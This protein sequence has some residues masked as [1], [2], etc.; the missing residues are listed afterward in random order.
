MRF[1]RQY[2]GMARQPDRTT[3]RVA[4]KYL[5]KI[6]A[7]WTMT[8]TANNHGSIGADAALEFLELLRPGGSWQIIAITADNEAPIVTVT[9]VDKQVVEQFI[10]K[11]IGKRNLYFTPNPVRPSAP[12]DKKPTK[13]EIA[14]IEYVYADLDP[15]DDETPEQAKARYF[16]AL[17]SSEQQP[18]FVVD[19]GNGLQA[20]FRVTPI[21]LPEPLDVIG[22]NNSRGLAYDSVTLA[23]IAN[24]EARIRALVLSLGGTAGTQN[25]DRALRLPG[26]V[27]VPN[28]A[29]R[30][31]GRVHCSTALLSAS[32]AER[33]I[34]DFPLP[35]D[36]QP[37][38]SAAAHASANNGEDELFRT[39]R[40]GGEKRHGAS[41][42]EAVWYVCCEMLRRGYLKKTIVKTLL[43]RA[44]AISAHVY[45][46][47][48]P[49]AYAEKQAA[50]AAAK[51]D[52]VLD[53]DTRP[54]KT[55]GNVR[56]ALVKLGIEL[57]YDS[58]AGRVLIEG[59][60]DFD[61]LDDAA[62]VRIWLTIDRRFSL[63][64]T[65]T[66]V[67]DVLLDVAQINAFHPVRDYLAGLKWD[68]EP[69]LDRWLTIY[70]GAVDNK[71]TN[72]VGALP[73]IAA[74]RRVRQPGVKFDEMLVLEHPVQGVS[75]RSS[76]LAIM[77]V[78]DEWFSDDLPLNVETKEFIER[79]RGR[80]IIEAGELAGLRKADVNHLKGLL[81]RR[82]DRARLAYGRLETECP[83]QC[84]IIATTNAQLYL[85]D[86][87]GNRRMWAVRVD[88]FDIEKL[89]ADRDQIWAEAAHRE[90]TG[91]SIRLDSSLWPVAE[92]EQAQRLID[93]P[94][95]ETLL[96]ELG[97]GF[98]QS[99]IS[100]EAVWVILDVKPGARTQELNCRMGDAMRRAGW[101][102]ANAANQVRIDGKK[103][104]G[105]TRGE[106]PW[107]TVRVRRSLN[108]GLVI[109]RSEL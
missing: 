72:A 47:A 96:S 63:R 28:K 93:D 4:D 83:R 51:L 17:E 3:R 70:G 105:Y 68:G 65:K 41:R 26:T 40:D 94:Y 90:A 31:R 36:A 102:R 61:K 18:T 8:D 34:E 86:L 99:K 15:R 80:W 71:Y 21:S 60:D 67:F 106:Q 77:A 64:V 75:M 6:E 27:N 5:P 82:I 79:T 87:T 89:A 43:D 39:I 92:R 32:A 100:S 66:L 46:Q 1:S 49:P 81:S 103:V 7:M 108:E 11:Y 35:D 69:R 23:L 12:P 42:S 52:L 33:S 57:S 53:G 22:P 38:A 19:S 50:D 84:V 45:E 2:E 85:R 101:K 104:A 9:T 14:A 91:A 20:L 13:L 98:D 10:K 37:N 59:L 54:F 95:S 16:S 107:Q 48:N 56:V 88:R 78:R 25:I 109:T 44:N 55:A 62:A 30:N 73:L 97:D 76:G 58:F 24:V 29:K 74:V